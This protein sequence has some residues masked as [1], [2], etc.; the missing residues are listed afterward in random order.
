M[1]FSRVRKKRI[2]LLINVYYYYKLA[3]QN[4]ATKWLCLFGFEFPVLVNY[5]QDYTIQKR[6]N[7]WFMYTNIKLLQRTYLKYRTLN[8]K[9]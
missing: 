4:N 8:F 7:N 5:I 3:K 6:K 1:P 9:L 2:K